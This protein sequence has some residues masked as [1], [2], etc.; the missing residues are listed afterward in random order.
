MKRDIE[1]LSVIKHFMSS[2]GWVEHKT[3]GVIDADSTRS[4]M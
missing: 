2:Y 1:D 4:Y 3:Q